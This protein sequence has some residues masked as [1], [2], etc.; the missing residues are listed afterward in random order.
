M[1]SAT[2][3]G[4]RLGAGSFGDGSTRAH[5]LHR[6]Q[7][8]VPAWDYVWRKARGLARQEWPWMAP[9]GRTEAESR[10]ATQAPVRRPVRL[11]GESAVVIDVRAE[12][13][14]R[15]VVD[16]FYWSG[17]NPEERRS[18]ATFHQ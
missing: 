2:C 14:T 7:D 16:S 4:G 3:P 5:V 6:N 8:A 15:L 9:R 18:I 11:L 12:R 10:I 13:P 1:T 17:P